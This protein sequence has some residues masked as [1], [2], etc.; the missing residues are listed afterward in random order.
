MARVMAVVLLPSRLTVYRQIMLMCREDAWV[1]VV[2]VA[3]VI[4]TAAAAVVSLDMT[5]VGDMGR[6]RTPR[7]AVIAVGEVGIVAARTS[8][9]GVGMAI[10]M[11]AIPMMMAMGAVGVGLVRDSGH[12]AR[13]VSNRPRTACLG[14]SA[15]GIAL[16][17]S[18][19]IVLREGIRHTGVVWG[20]AVTSIS[21]TR[22]GVLAHEL[23]EDLVMVF[24][25]NNGVCLDRGGTKEL[26]T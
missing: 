22:A 2:Q 6:G 15:V 9:M 7:T 16:V 5:R 24:P 26:G 4:S 11:N 17:A 3:M 1:A 25:F 8:T 18:R 12:L 13:N 23:R 19:Q 21:N 20:F 10:A 14:T